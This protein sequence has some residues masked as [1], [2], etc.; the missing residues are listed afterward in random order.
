[1][2]KKIEGLDYF[3]DSRSQE[4]QHDTE[5]DVAMCIREQQVSILENAL[6]LARAGHL[7]SLVLQ[8]HFNEE[9]RKKANGCGVG[10]MACPGDE[11]PHLLMHLTSMVKKVSRESGVPILDTDSLGGL[12]AALLPI[13]NR[14]GEEDDEEHT[15]PRH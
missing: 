8:L 6:L 14:R 10:V 15:G 9:S 3:L 2:D 11:I 5:G 12:L 4:I 7:E 1:M 13:I